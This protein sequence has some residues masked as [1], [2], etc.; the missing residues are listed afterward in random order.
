M[1]DRTHAKY[2][3][4]LFLECIPYS[5]EDWLGKNMNQLGGIVSEMRGTITFLRK[6]GIIHFDAHFGNILT[7]GE[8]PYLTDFGLV[9]DRRFELIDAERQFFNKHTHYDYGKFLSDLGD[10]ANAPPERPKIP[11]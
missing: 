9:L 6:N 4:V 11:I 3:V 1:I 5:L 2:E 10:L 8:K 7:D